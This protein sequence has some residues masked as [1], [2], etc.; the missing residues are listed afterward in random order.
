MAVPFFPRGAAWS[1]SD[2]VRVVDVDAFDAA[3]ARAAAWFVARGVPRGSRVVLV[4]KSSIDAVVVLFGA[5]RAGLV[6]VPANPGYQAHELGHVVV[7]SGAVLVVVDGDGAVDL[8]AGAGTDV[9]AA[10]IV[11]DGSKDGVRVVVEGETSPPRPPSPQAERGEEK[12]A[13]HD[14]A[15]IVVDVVD[16][17]D[18][19]VGRDVDDNDLA[20]LIYTSGTTG[21]AKGCAHTFGGLAAGIGALMELWGVGDVDVVVNPLP[22][23]HVHGLCVCLLGALLRGASVRLVPHFSAE[24]VVDVVDV[25]GG[26]VL[27]TVPTMVHRLLALLDGD[28]TSSDAAERGRR[29]LARLR[30]ATCGSAALSAAQ[31]ERFRAHTG[32]TLLERYGM[33]ETL[34][35]LSNPLVGERR[36]GAVGWPVPGTRVRVVDDELW[37]SAPGMM[38]GYW[39]RPDADREVFVDDD[40]GRWFRTGDVVDVAADGCVRIVGRASQDIVKVGGFK[41]A[42]REIEE[43]LEGAAA[44][45][46]VS[47]VGVPD[48]EWGEQIVAVVVL[49]P[50]HTL[51]LDEA[52]AHTRLASVKKPRRLVVVD[53]L[54]RNGLG[55][56]VKPAVRSLVLGADNNT[57]HVRGSGRGVSSSTSGADRGDEGH[58]RSPRSGRAR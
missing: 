10:R 32:L 11:V 19:V 15:R 41:I 28:G 46:E 57:T 12:Q 14:A 44:V 35:T 34:I 52:Q 53:A 27:M 21:R 13:A 17:V 50:G 55:K 36:P 20:L 37:V 23:F 49:R 56:V 31:L 1:L 9:V 39:Q 58:R 4:T 43:Q 25:A 29:V 5:W 18:V 16:V 45:A 51:S 6:V 8:G 54:P 2:G 38:R 26:T 42:T 3:T 22:L 33:S 47:V 7:D 40:A 30:L 24:A 48:D